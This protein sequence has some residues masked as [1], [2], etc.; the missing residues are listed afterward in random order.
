VF[1]FN[2]GE[3]PAI[4]WVRD[5]GYDEVASHVAHGEAWSTVARQAQDQLPI[6]GPMALPELSPI[7]PPQSTQIRVTTRAAVRMSSLRAPRLA[8]TGASQ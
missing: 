6:V 2:V 1:Q 5:I 8:A 7:A 4:G 3:I